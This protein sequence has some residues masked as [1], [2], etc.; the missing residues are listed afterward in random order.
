[1][2]KKILHIGI[3]NS[4]LMSLWTL[5]IGATAV[6]PANVLAD[7]KIKIQP[8]PLPPQSRRAIS[9]NSYLRTVLPPSTFV[10]LRIPTVWGLLGSPTDNVFAKAMRTAPQVNA[11]LRIR[12]GI[13]A[14]V[15][16]QIPEP[17]HKLADLLLANISSPLELL[18][19]NQKMGLRLV[20]Q[21]LL[22]ASLEQQDIAA[23]NNLLR[24]IV[25]GKPNLALIQP[26]RPDGSGRLLAI[27]KPVEIYFD[28]A[29]QRLFLW[30]SVGNDITGPITKQLAILQPTTNHPMHA[31]ESE[32]DKTGQGLLLWIDPAAM[33]ELL[34]N[35]GYVQDA[36]K[37]RSSGVAEASTLALGM[38]S[39]GGKQRLKLLLNMPVVGLRNLLPT[40]RTELPFR[41]AGKLMTALMLGLPQPE[42]LQ[43][44]EATL[45]PFVSDNT[46]L[47]YLAAKIMVAKM[48]GLTIEDILATFGRELL[49]IHDQ[50]GYYAALRVQNF[51]N[52]R[53]LLPRLVQLLEA[54]YETR[55]L[56][57]TTF[58]QLSLP[59]ISEAKS[60]STTNQDSD[61]FVNV[62][63]PGFMQNL[64]SHPSNLY[65]AEIPG[66]LILADV[67]QVLMDSMYITPKVSVKNWLQQ[68][69]G[70]DPTG[71]LFLASTTATGAP[72]FLYGI[73]LWML[74]YLGELTQRPIDLFQMPSAYELKLPDQGSY[75]LQFTSNAKQLALELVYESNPLELFVTVGGIP[76]L[77]AM[78]IA[79]AVIIPSLWADKPKTL[80]RDALGL[81][82]SNIADIATLRSCLAE[83]RMVMGRFPAD[84]ADIATCIDKTPTLKNL[85]VIVTPDAG[86]ITIRLPSSDNHTPEQ[87]LIL[88]PITQPNGNLYWQCGGS[89]GI[90]AILPELCTQ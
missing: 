69:Q 45:R 47:G 54:R 5:P 81:H 13:L 76:T 51:A 65:W 3:A 83:F 38:G 90:D 89:T 72:Q 43:R 11:I 30:F 68:S 1:M 86:V 70:L 23:V 77:V 39:S 61:G 74:S 57:N 80:S 24:T 87:E 78:G 46:Y 4:L 10:Y 53:Q 20:P 33:T 41:A 44:L 34:K 60:A 58:H 31:V 8:R 48:L 50:A 67:P 27:D 55:E 2:H 29:A 12:N 88:T 56:L 15:L 22:T 16:P 7:G 63:I 85:Q 32:L 21:V 40:I 25:A 9:T 79:S 36:V 26:L 14:N 59:H 84:A 49:L 71:A 66:Y 75:S 37:L 62:E 17:W 52:Y 6:D 64:L 18:V 82:E 73:H 35:L 19:F 42:D 28:V